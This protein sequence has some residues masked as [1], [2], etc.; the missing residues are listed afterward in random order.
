MSSSRSTIHSREN[1]NSSNSSSGS[2]SR[3]CFVKKITVVV[4]KTEVS[5]SDANKLKEKSEIFIRR[6]SVAG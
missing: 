1:S 6:V 3:G 2:C 5:D 4:A